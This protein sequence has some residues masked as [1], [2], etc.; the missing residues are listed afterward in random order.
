MKQYESIRR[1]AC[2]LALLLD[3]RHGQDLEFGAIVEGNIGKID[4]SFQ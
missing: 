1:K 3:Q 2:A 4:Y